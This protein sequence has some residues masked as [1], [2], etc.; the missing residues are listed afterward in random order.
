MRTVLAYFQLVNFLAMIFITVFVLSNYWGEFQDFWLLLYGYYVIL[1][2]SGVI[3]AAWIGIDGNRLQKYATK[4]QKLEQKL[5]DL[6]KK[7][8]LIL[9]REKQED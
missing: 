3:M 5:I 6:E 7:I 4:M 8:R 1:G 9:P 2:C